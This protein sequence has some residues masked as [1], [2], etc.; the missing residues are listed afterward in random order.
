MKKVIFVLLICLTGCATPGIQGRYYENERKITI[1][2][3]E[4]TGPLSFIQKLMGLNTLP[5]GKYKFQF[6]ENVKGEIDSK[7]DIKIIDINMM[8]TGA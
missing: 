6:D 5:A 1:S 8:R 3:I 2:P 4:P 7:T